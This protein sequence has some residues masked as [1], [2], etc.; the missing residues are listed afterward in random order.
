[1][2]CTLPVPTILSCRAKDMSTR[3]KE[4]QRLGTVAAILELYLG[5]LPL[6][7]TDEK[8]S[9]SKPQMAT[10]MAHALQPFCSEQ[11]VPLVLHSSSLSSS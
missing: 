6:E 11:I 1:M 8:Q 5:P 3:K 2:L 7:K 4:A 10:F 9:T